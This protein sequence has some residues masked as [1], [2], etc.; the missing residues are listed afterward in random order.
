MRHL[1]LLMTLLVAC[2]GALAQQPPATQ[3]SDDDQI[4][5]VNDDDGGRAFIVP[6]GNFK[7]LTK[8]RRFKA[9]ALA[10]PEQYS[11]FLGSGWST[12]Q[13]RAREPR[14]SNLLSSIRNPGETE[15]LATYGIENCFAPTVSQE[16][17]T[18]FSAD[19]KLSDILTRA[20]L[21]ELVNS[22]SLPRSGPSSIYVVFLEPG[23][24]STLG[25][26]TGRKHYLAYHHSFNVAGQR[27]HYVVVPY[28]PDLERAQAIAL[29]V[30]VAAALNPLGEIGN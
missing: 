25:T 14:L 15:N 6:A 27:L 10:E 5:A 18:N 29:R 20:A 3:N 13:L 9:P 8:L 17:L 24:G 28:E 19:E 16:V 12:P 30:F 22:G 21:A 26:L 7:R 2:G 23:L 4:Q 11:I 1:L